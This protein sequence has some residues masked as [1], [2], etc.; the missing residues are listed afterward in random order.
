MSAILIFHGGDSTFINSFDNTKFLLTAPH[1]S[2]HHDK[3]QTYYFL[4]FSPSARTTV[5]PEQSHTGSLDDE[6]TSGWLQTN[7]LRSSVDVTCT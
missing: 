3:E 4:F 2:E 6:T 5:P 1:R 7:G